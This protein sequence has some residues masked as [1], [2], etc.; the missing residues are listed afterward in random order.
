MIPGSH[1]QHD[2][3][4]MFEDLDQILIELAHRRADQVAYGD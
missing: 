3:F 4:G 1:T 2:R